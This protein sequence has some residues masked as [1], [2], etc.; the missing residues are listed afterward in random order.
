MKDVQRIAIVDPSDAT[1]EPL[2]NLLLAVES[3]WLEAECSRYEFLIDVARQSCPEIIV[4]AALVRI[5]AGGMDLAAKNGADENLTICKAKNSDKEV[6]TLL[7]AYL[8]PRSSKH[9]YLFR[10][11][12]PPTPIILA[13]LCVAVYHSNAFD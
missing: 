12:N 6:L 9:E 2:R 1:R 8:L 10:E 3:V 4:D 5:A 11:F 13:L 7:L